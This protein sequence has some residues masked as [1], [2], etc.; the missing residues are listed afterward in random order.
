MLSFILKVKIG[1]YHAHFKS[2][3]TMRG[4]LSVHQISLT[5]KT[6]IFKYIEYHNYKILYIFL[7]KF[8]FISTESLEKSKNNYFGMSL[9]IN[10]HE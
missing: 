6:L 8:S 2:R 9:L 5:S 4:T 10:F 3:R 1:F 7:L